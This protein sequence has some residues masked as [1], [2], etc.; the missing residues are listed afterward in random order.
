MPLSQHRVNPALGLTQGIRVV[1]PIM[2]ELAGGQ[3]SHPPGCGWPGMNASRI[4]T[5]LL[6]LGLGFFFLDQ[7][8]NGMPK[9]VENEFWFCGVYGF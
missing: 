8:P 5:G 3:S 7:S 6:V 2:G 9:I 1:C 4:A